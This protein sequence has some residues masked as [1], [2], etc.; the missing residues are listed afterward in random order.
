MHDP[1]I[2]KDIGDRV[3]RKRSDHHMTQQ[4]L[5]IKADL[6]IQTIRQLEQGTKPSSVITLR[7][8]TEAL[9]TTSD[10]LLWGDDMPLNSAEFV[11]DV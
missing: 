1:Q 3:A 5:S 4:D 2:L 11:L 7:Q 8:V 10:H 9:E 6:A